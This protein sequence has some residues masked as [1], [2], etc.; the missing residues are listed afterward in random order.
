MFE[1]R[2][3]VGRIELWETS[4][5]HLFYERRQHVTFYVRVHSLG[6][7]VLDLFD[8][9]PGKGQLMTMLTSPE[10]RSKASPLVSE[11]VITDGTWHH[12]GL[13][14]DGIFRHLYVDGVEVA[15]DVKAMGVKGTQSGMNIGAA[16]DLAPGSFWK[17]LVDD[18]R[19][20]DRIVKP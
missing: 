19:I 11:R 7:G 8:Y 16:K 4:R 9:G 15:G 5:E 10:G 14:Y 1:N 18:V 12:V 13:V 17:G 3:G 2:V 20:Y 6:Y